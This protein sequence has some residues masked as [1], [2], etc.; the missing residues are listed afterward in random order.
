VLYN[1]ENL[2]EVSELASKLGE[3]PQNIMRDLMELQ[4]K[5]LLEI[6]QLRRYVL[7]LTDDGRKY[8]VKG[9]PEERLYKV[10][11]KSGNEG[12]VIKQAIHEA[13]LTDK[14]FKAAI[15]ILRKLDIIQLRKGR[16]FVSGDK[17]K[18][19][20]HVNSINR[21]LR[22]IAEGCI[23]ESIN[24]YIKTLSKR[25]MIE[26]EEKTLIYIKPTQQLLNKYNK[27]EIV[28]SFIVTKVTPELITS[29]KWEKATFKEF[30]LNVEVPE[31]YP[32]KKHPYL[33]F[34]NLVRYIVMSMG[35]EEMR[36][37]HIETELWNFDVLYVPQ[38]HPS[39]RE[40]D[41]YFIRKPARKEEP[42]EVIK[43][44]KLIHETG[45]QTGSI[46]W[47]YTWS[48]ER[49]LRLVLRTHTTPVS[50]RT[51]YL[52][53]GG[54]YRAFSLD[55]VFRPDTPDPTH[56][57][58]FHQLEGII[59]GKRVTFKDLLGFFQE[60]A[61]ALGLG[62]VRFRPA[63]FPFTEPSVEGYI[64]HPKLGWIEVFPG[65]MFRPEV[66][67]AVGLKG[68]NVAAWGIGIDRIAMMFLGIDDI[69]DL[70]TNKLSVIRSMTI[71]KGVLK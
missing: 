70:Y 55:R 23:V 18:L 15:G 54:E 61:N 48:P 36:G 53:K 52:K 25:G 38:Y 4:T 59:V 30:D 42:E 27:G 2:I 34:L 21:I 5:G 20:K 65:G 24:D 31:I 47:R 17:E 66:L 1:I 13:E 28:E 40:T 67:E 63:Y 33:Q 41:V 49:A 35:F 44:V 68:Y 32:S 46:G 45:G 16:L 56:L 37:P 12:I 58:E 6:S 11:A 71:P 14:E 22:K 3:R 29:G 57:M 10:V 43:R 9:L 69:R 8:L 7:K 26:I 50:M 19:V 60:F 51:L 62:K 39:R 64:K